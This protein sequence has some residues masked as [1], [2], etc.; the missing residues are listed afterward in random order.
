MKKL[1]FF[2]S[3]L[4]AVPV[5]AQD[6]GLYFRADCNTL[7][8]VAY[9]TLC[10]QTTTTVDRSAGLYSYNGATWIS[11]AG[12]G[13]GTPG[14]ATT[15]VQYNSVGAFAG[16]AGLTYNAATDALTAVTFIGALTGNAAT[17][18]ALAANGSNCTAGNYPLGVDAA[19]N[20]ETCTAITAVLLGPILR[21]NSMMAE[22]L[23]ALTLA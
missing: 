15:Q 7:S 9:S 20:V 6:V 3:L 12:G 11:A 1:L 8:G 21:C 13:A 17:A 10:Q 14:G 5:Y 18:S 4:L 2:L 19:G 22:R 23:S 16:D